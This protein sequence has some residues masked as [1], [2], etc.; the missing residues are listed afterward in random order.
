MFCNNGNRGKMDTLQKRMLRTISRNNDLNLKEL[1]IKYDTQTIHQKH[2]QS[3]ML[4]IYKILNNKSPNLISNL[5]TLKNNSEKDKG[6][7]GFF[8]S[9]PLNILISKSSS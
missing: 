3:L 9:H 2:I 8:V 1:I 7:A 5:F 4:E 6:Q